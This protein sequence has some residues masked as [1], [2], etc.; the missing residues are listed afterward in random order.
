MT[1][2]RRE[3][4]HCLPSPRTLQTNNPP[5]ARALHLASSS[6]LPQ[7]SAIGWRRYRGSFRELNVGLKGGK[8]QRCRRKESRV[9]RLLSMR[10][11]SLHKDPVSTKVRAATRGGRATAFGGHNI[12]PASLYH[13]PHALIL[14]H[15]CFLLGL[16]NIERLE[17]ERRCVNP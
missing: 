6:Q 7:H 17:I 3:V 8:Y 4:K 10:P 13:W 15:D 11:K 12:H 16:V 1:G 2:G 5:D 9:C 14:E